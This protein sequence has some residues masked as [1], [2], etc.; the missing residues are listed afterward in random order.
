[1]SILSPH[2]SRTT[3]KQ[4]IVFQPPSEMGS[5]A[6]SGTWFSEEK[7]VTE[8]PQYMQISSSDRLWIQLLETYYQFDS[9]PEVIDFLI[10]NQFLVGLLLDAPEQI[11]KCFDHNAEL[12]LRLASEPEEDDSQELF[13]F[14][15][16][17]L[18]VDEALKR[19]NTLDEEWWLEASYRGRC[20][21][22]I[23]VEC[24]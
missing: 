7:F 12:V 13:V 23:D 1:M 16:T 2:L 3:G 21:L 22:N 11:K 17:R 20:L 14:I 6:S 19:L 10:K 15:M 24:T 18:P 4:E 8:S 9:A 5:V